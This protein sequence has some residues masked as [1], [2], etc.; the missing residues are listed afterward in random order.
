MFTETWSVPPGTTP[1]KVKDVR[2]PSPS[3]G[4]VPPAPITGTIEE[5]DVIG[6]LADLEARA[7][8]GPGFAP[9]RVAIVNSTG[10]LETALGADGDCVRVDGSSGPCGGGTSGSFADAQ[11]LAGLA[12]TQAAWQLLP[13]GRVPGSCCGDDSIH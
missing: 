3:G 5:S 9:G 4:G 10:A 13:T 6:L 11:P 2:V 12:L 1:L 8:K 7:I